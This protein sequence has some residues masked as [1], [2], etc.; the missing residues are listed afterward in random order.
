MV[1][2]DGRYHKISDGNVVKEVILEGPSAAYA[3]FGILVQ[4]EPPSRESAVHEGR[5]DRRS[6]FDHIH[7]DAGV[8]RIGDI[9]G[10]PLGHELSTEELAVGEF[11]SQIVALV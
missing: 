8:Q 2:D 1:L 10:R 4:L 9:D 11:H 6:R 5:T 3:C 7:A